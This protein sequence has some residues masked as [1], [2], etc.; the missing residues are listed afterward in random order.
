MTGLITDED[1]LVI[2]DQQFDE[3]CDYPNCDAARTHMLTC[4]ECPAAENMCEAHA[5]AAKLAKPKDR[6][7]F[8]NTCLHTVFMIHCGKIRMN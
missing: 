5:T 4:P 1:I 6:V 2:L 7:V 3:A 8:N